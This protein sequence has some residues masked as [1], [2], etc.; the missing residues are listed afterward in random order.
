VRVYIGGQNLLTI[1]KSSGDNKFTGLDPENPG[2]G[3]PIPVTLTAG[4]NI[5]L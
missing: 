1:K 5:S 4:L 3:Y 2:W